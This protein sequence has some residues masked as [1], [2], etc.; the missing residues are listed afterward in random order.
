MVGKSTT[1][2]VDMQFSAVAEF[3]TNTA[4]VWGE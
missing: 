2:N 4:A 1:E 3:Y